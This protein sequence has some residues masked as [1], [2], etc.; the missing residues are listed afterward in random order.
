[1]KIVKPSS[2]LLKITNGACEL[3][4]IAGRTCYQSRR[5][6]GPGTAEPFVAKLIA[7][8][9]ESVLEHAVATFS[10]VCDRGTANELVRHRIISPS[11]E[12]QRY[13]D[14]SGELEV[15]EP[16]GLLPEDVEDWTDAVLAGEDIYKHLRGRGYKP[17]I[18]RSVLPTCVKTEIVITANFREWRHIFRM[19]LSKKA[20]PQIR[21]IMGMAHEVLLGKYPV[22]FNMGVE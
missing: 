2:A 12:S 15:I 20:H 4:E 10:F 21:E 1:M 17:E 14:Y 22:I 6:I 9:H 19:R 3:I 11:Q 16:P 7:L 18:A 8:G 5:M 13:C